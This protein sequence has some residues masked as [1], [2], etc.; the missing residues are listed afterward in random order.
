MFFPF[1]VSSRYLK[2]QRKSG[3]ISL[4]AY[5]SMTGVALGTAALIITLAVMAGFERELRIKFVNFD[6]HLRFRTFE[7]TEF[8]DPETGL[9]Q[10][11][12]EN[13]EISGVS[14]YIEREAM[15]RSKQVTDGVIVKGI[16]ETR[17]DEALN[18]RR[19]VVESK[20]NSRIHL[21]QDTSDALPGILIGQKLADRLYAKVGDK[22]TLFSLQGTIAFIQQPSVRQYILTGIYRSGLSEYDNVYVYVDLNEAQKLFKM[23]STIHGYELRLKNQMEATT[24]QKE[25]TKAFGYPYYVRT[26]LDV[27]RNLFGWLET[28]HYIM[29]IIFG[30]IILVAAFNIV[31]T[32]FIIV[33]EKTRDIGILKSMGAKQ[34]A[35]ARIFLFEGL[36]I[37]LMGSAA[38]ASLAYVICRVQQDFRILALDSDVYFMD[39]VPMEIKW[40]FFAGMIL[41]S[42]LLCVLATVLPSLRA[43]RLD[44]VEAIRYE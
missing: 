23:G 13:Q 28:N 1:F 33:I 29:T 14:P 38:G 26:W 12:R 7:G 22:L 36:F 16:D 32:L 5:I 25:L 6:S 41:F 17:V 4:I 34:K 15:I 30:L 19:D 10:K 31:G 8:I 42:T 2:A 27:H 39:S 35:I 24:V 37:G 18:I 44:A 20:Y 21:K 3:F 9:E 11:L 40:Q 43:A